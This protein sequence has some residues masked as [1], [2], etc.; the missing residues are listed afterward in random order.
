LGRNPELYFV[1]IDRSLR[2]AP[3]ANRVQA[4]TVGARWA[5]ENGWGGPPGG[6]AWP[7]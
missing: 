7:A 5:L 4:W 6:P 1:D 3:V 2:P